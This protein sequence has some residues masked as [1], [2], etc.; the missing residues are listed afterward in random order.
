[1]Q[2]D[3]N[4]PRA[5]S[6]VLLFERCNNETYTG[7]VCKSDEYITSWLRRKFVVVNANM[8][9]FAT[10]QFDDTTKITDEARFEYIPINSQIRE[11]IVYKV[12]LTDL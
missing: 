10:R 1:M 2:G 11:E 3:Y 12:Q 7:G 5:R 6:F 8:E 9:R 4:S